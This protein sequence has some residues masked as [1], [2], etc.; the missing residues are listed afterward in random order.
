MNLRFRLGYFLVGILVFLA[1][2]L[3]ALY[4]RDRIIRP[5]GGDY[6]VVIMIYCFVRAFTNLAVL[7]AAI[8]VLLLAY[9]I[10]TLQYLNLV[11]ILGLT[12]SRLANVV[13]G[14]SF[15]WIDIIAYTLGIMSVIAWEK[16]REASI[17]QTVAR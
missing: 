6:L 13:L 10:E 15:A 2:I 1:E 7:T 14:N 8:S 5:Y 16:W 4:V 12:D 9:L 3:I 17:R 11:S